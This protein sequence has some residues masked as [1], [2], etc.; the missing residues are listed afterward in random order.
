MTTSKKNNQKRPKKDY[1]E[2]G[3]KKN[4]H[5]LYSLVNIGLHTKK[6]LF[7]LPGSALKVPGGWYQWWVVRK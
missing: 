6:W 7:T 1:I 3:L 2:D 4:S 5:I